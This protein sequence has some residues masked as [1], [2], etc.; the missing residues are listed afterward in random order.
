M[1]CSKC[2]QK[3]TPKDV[4]GKKHTIEDLNVGDFVGVRRLEGD[5]DQPQETE[6]VLLMLIAKIREVDA[7]RGQ[8]EVWWMYGDDW[9]GT[10]YEWKYK[11]SRKAF[12]R[13]IDVSSIVQVNHKWLKIQMTKK[14]GT[15]PHSSKYLIDESSVVTIIEFINE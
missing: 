6:Y 4:K 13:W 8:V 15:I 5:I 10:W 12:I 14:S 7:K 11:T 1:T 3:R 9:Y 2:L